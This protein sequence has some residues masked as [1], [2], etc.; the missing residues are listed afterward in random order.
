VSSACYAPIALKKG[1]YLV[2]IKRTY[3]PGEIRRVED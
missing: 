3:E 1:S 2:R